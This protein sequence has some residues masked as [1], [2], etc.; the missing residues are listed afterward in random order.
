[1][2]TFNASAFL[3]KFRNQ[4]FI[5]VVG[6]GAQQLVNAGRSE[7]KGLELEAA[8]R[9]AAGPSF[10]PRLGLL[11]S[12]YKEM[13]RDGVDLAGNELIAAPHRPPTPPADYRIQI[14]AHG[15]LNF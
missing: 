1:M 11:A 9:P 13:L 2:L 6:I 3:Y 12:E 4:Q 15:S 10:T 14:G 5:N 8:L 7:I